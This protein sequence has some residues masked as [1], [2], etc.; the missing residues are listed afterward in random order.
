MSWL[1]S[2]SVRVS[3][4]CDCQTNKQF[5]VAQ[6]KIN[7]PDHVWS[8]QANKFI[9]V[10]QSGLRKTG[11]DCRVVKHCDFGA[12][13]LFQDDKTELEYSDFSPQVSF[14]HVNSSEVSLAAATVAAA[15]IRRGA[16]LSCE[17]LLLWRR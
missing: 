7:Q 8:Y 6:K 9:S 4:L 15:L 12:S 1:L 3:L 2:S 16:T 11:A 14:T 13:L 5:L 10:L 17:H